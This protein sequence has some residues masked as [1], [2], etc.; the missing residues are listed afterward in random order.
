MIL[1]LDN[2]GVNLQDLGVRYWDN[3]QIAFPEI[4]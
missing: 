4:Q 2:L 3:L 1:I